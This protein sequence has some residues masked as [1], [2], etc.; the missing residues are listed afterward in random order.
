MLLDRERKIAVKKFNLVKSLLMMLAIVLCLAV[1]VSAKLT[2]MEGHWSEEYV[3]FGIESGYI[4]GYTDGTFKPDNSVN[5]AEFA[6][7]INSALGLS[8]TAEVEF[9]DVDQTEWYYAEVAKAVN[10]GFINGYED[11][12]F[13]P[14]NII[15][16]QE[17]AVILSRIGTRPEQTLDISKLSDSNDIDEWAKDSFVYAYSKGYFSGDEYGKLNPKD[18][19]TRGQAAKLLH[20]L[21]KSDNMVKG[22]YTVTLGNGICSETIFAD[23]VYFTATA[24]EPTLKIDGCKIMGTLYIRST[25]PCVVE[26]TDSSIKELI[27]DAGTATVT[28]GDKSKIKKVKMAVPATVSGEGVS[29]I[30]LNGSELSTGT[31]ELMVPGVKVTLYSNAVIK[32]GSLMSL[33]V[34][35]SSSVNIQSGDIK[36]MT[37]AKAAAGSVVTLS[38]GVNIDNL[39]VSGACSFMG[40]GKIKNA[41]NKVAGVSY[42]VAPEKLTGIASSEGTADKNTFVPASVSPKDTEK[43]VAISAIISINFGKAVYD[44]NGKLIDEEYIVKNVS[45]NQRTASGTKI[46]Y[47]PS[48]RST[49]RFEMDPDGILAANTKYYI[50]IPAGVFADANGNKN[51][52]LSYTFT[53][54][55]AVEDYDDYDDDSSSASVSKTIKFD[56]DNGD[57]KVAVSD[58]IRITFGSAIRRQ[59]GASATN[60]YLANTAFELREKTA[61]GD[62]VSISAEINSTNKI[63]TL[64]SDEPLK[65]GTRYYIIL[66]AGSLEFSGDGANISK[67]T[68]YFTTSDEIG[69]L[70]S[71][72][73]A[74]T[75]VAQDTK[76][77]I[78][79]NCPIIRASGSNLTA[80][81]V[82]EEGV[83]LR[84]GSA[85]GARVD[86]TAEVSSDKKKITITPNDTLEASKKYYVI[87]P[88]NM[89]ASGD[90]DNIENK[91]LTAYFT[92]AASMSPVITP[93]NKSEGVDPALPIK[94]SFSDALYDKNGDR[95]TEEYILDNDVIFLRKNSSSGTK[96]DFDVSISKD[97]KTI[98]ITPVKALN[99]NATYYVSVT[100]SKLYNEAKKT[101]TAATSSFRTASSSAPEIIPVDGDKDVPVDTKIEI[102]FDN[103]MYQVGGDTLTATYIKNNVVE[104]YKD[105][106]DGESVAFSVTLSSDKNTFIIK[107]SKALDGDTTYLVVVR[108]SSLEDGN[109]KENIEYRSSF[110]TAEA[111][112]TGCDFLPVNNEKNVKID[113]DITVTF[114]NAVYR[115]NGDIASAAYIRN[116]VIELR[117]GSSSGTIIPFTATMSDDNKI[118]TITPEKALEANT[119]YYV[120]VIASKLIYSDNSYVK[121]ATAYFTTASYTPA[122][123]AVTISEITDTTA[124]VS[125]TAT[126]TGYLDLSY[127]TSGAGE[128]YIVSGKELKKGE[129]AEFTLTGLKGETRYTVNAVM[130]D[131][132]DIESA[133]EES[134]TTKKSTEEVLEITRIALTDDTDGSYSKAISGGTVD[135]TIT[136][137]TKVKLA[138]TASVKGAIVEVSGQDEDGFVA[139]ESGD[140]QIT[141]TVTSPNTGKEVVCVVNVHVN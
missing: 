114:N 105:N 10:A 54:K 108:E 102:T 8:K 63:V 79:F 64:K 99:S 23:D 128:E 27:L 90:N 21:K 72:K 20:G 134:F 120:K 37:V 112:V 3:N 98:T 104:L 7:M 1:A 33:D 123:G 60:S 69:I 71:P 4:N 41:N 6:K 45:I 139:V 101:N 125:V 55:A 51:P 81:F 95:I 127:K 89:F 92:T 93:A 110:T 42:E 141:V 107:P 2:D 22:D 117:K 84:M 70:V 76:I 50:T 116:N 133:K 11:G 130:F 57:T 30:E 32:A 91:K 131:V 62:R 74:S 87:I 46:Y 100:K 77:E 58:D 86:F 28:L 119:K 15:T 68:S 53:T 115:T 126:A 136:S 140:N 13:R 106:Y 9:Y 52:K 17:A 78:E 65:P 44:T 48:I 47:E 88:A 59:S 135:F 73:S 97:Y 39:E 38:S 118:I 49:S 67:K 5:R 82:E 61:T 36:S 138:V 109:S 40:K 80:S 113:T 75:G 122:L 137:A 121:A 25:K 26:I 18:I 12:S 19:L 24:D 14:N 94:I 85:S 83:E 16:R 43:D 103:Q 34:R 129:T 132:D 96:L 111:I 35:S 31:T 124:I 56:P 66:T 29:E